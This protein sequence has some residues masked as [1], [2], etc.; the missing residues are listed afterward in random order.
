MS[1]RDLAQVFKRDAP[2]T[3]RGRINRNEIAQAPVAE[4]RSRSRLWFQPRRAPCPIPVV[5]A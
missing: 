3:I 2:L 1:C 5:I 4:R